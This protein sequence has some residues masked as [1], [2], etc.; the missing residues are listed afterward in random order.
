[1]CVVYVYW[2]EWVAETLFLGLFLFD[3]DLFDFLTLIIS[4]GQVALKANSC[5]LFFSMFI[6]RSGCFLKCL[7]LGII[8]FLCSIEFGTG[9]L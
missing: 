1:M 7:V 5:S 6:S 8:S 4:S 3:F 2:L 9:G